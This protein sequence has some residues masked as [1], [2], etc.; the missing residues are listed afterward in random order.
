MSESSQRS[1][2]SVILRRKHSRISDHRS[3]CYAAKTRFLEPGAKDVSSDIGFATRAT[4]AQTTININVYGPAASSHANGRHLSACKVWLQRPDWHRPGCVY[5]NPHVIKTESAP[6][7]IPQALNEGVSKESETETLQ[8][9]IQEVYSML[10]RDA[11]LSTNASG[12]PRLQT[13]L[14]PHQAKALDFMIQRE[15]GPIPEQFELWE[16]VVQNGQTWYQHK[17]AGIKSRMRPT[18]TG[19]GVLADEMGMGK[20]FSMLSLLVNSLDA[21]AK[22]ATDPE[23]YLTDN[24]IPSKK[25]SRA[26]LVVVPSPLLLATWTDEIE[27]RLKV[28]LQVY[29]HH[30]RDRATDAEELMNNDVVLTTYH[31][32]IADHN[33]QYSPVAGI[34]W[35]RIILDE[36]HFIRSPTTY[37]HK[38]VA[39]LDAKF[40]WCLTGTPIQNRLDDIGALFAFLRIFPF[41]RLNIFRQCVSV[42]FKDGGKM[43]HVARRNLAKLLDAFCIRRMKVLLNLA[44]F[45]EKTRLVSF[46]TEEKEQYDKTYEDMKRAMGHTIN[47]SMN[48]KRFGIFQAQ[49]QLRLLCNHGTFQHQFH[50][51][52]ARNLLDEREDALTWSSLDWSNGEGACSSCHQLIPTIDLDAACKLQDRCTHM[53]CQEC[54]QGIGGQCP[55]CQVTALG[56]RGQKHGGSSRMQQAREAYFQHTGHSSKMNALIQE[57]RESDPQD[58][59]YVRKHPAP[60]CDLLT[61]TALSSLTGPRPWILWV[62]TFGTMAWTLNASTA[63]MN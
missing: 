18:E 24:I 1:S 43:K 19:G 7:E 22:W 14:L 50:W 45:N 49:L 4:D 61:G 17:V 60:M 33:K 41:D 30:G 51:A 57:L 38:R 27:T 2:P 3:S 12:D 56:Q 36:A 37:L 9:S 13:S 53:L 31:T 44:K 62:D 16:S 21:A 28:R 35:Y 59:W 55:L 40:R 5:D 10:T 48:S 46:S 8:N 6:N 58:K 15:N 52:R 63:T 42:P 20:T 23:T 29:T 39:E 47:E 11:H 54:R 34:A 26:T 32:L 25:L